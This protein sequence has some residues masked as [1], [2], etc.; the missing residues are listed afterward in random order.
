MIWVSPTEKKGIINKQIMRNIKHHVPTEKP[1]NK[2]SLTAIEIII[3]NTSITM[4]N[5]K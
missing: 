3:S 1:D 2:P 4:T 5:S